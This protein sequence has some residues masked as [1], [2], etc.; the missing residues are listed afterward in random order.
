M[1]PSFKLYQSQPACGQALATFETLFPPDAK[2][3]TIFHPRISLFPISF[4]AVQ[5]VLYHPAVE[6]ADLDKTLMLFL[7]CKN[8]QIVILG[9]SIDKPFRSVF[10]EHFY[11]GAHLSYFP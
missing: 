5:L 10:L 3:L 9:E 1:V 4:S 8:H 7:L 11:R 2:L 6:L